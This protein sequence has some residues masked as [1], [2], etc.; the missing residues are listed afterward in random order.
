MEPS[1]PPSIGEARTPPTSLFA[2]LTNLFVAPGEVFDE[3]KASKRTPA[4]WIVP[5]VISVI[6]SVIYTLVVFS[7]PAVIQRMQEAQGK[8]FEE[9]V[10]TGKMTQQKA[11]QAVAAVEKIMSPGFLKILGCLSSV[12]INAA[13]LFFTALI[14][15]AVGSRALQADFHYLKA[16]EAVGI[17]NMIN[18]VG[19]IV[20]MLLAVIYGD[21]SMTPGPALLIKP[22]DAANKVHLMLSALNLFSLWY[23]GVLSL[24]LARMTGADFSKTAGWLF[25][26]WAALT[27]GPIWLFGGK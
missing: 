21:M 10:A 24:G 15:W 22:F 11:D 7:Q 19:T 9:L 17:S 16:V 2:R 13:L 23:V 8:K 27:F 3:I 20:A 5:L 4:N 25:G 1:L 26:I 18:V 6:A 12:L 14:F